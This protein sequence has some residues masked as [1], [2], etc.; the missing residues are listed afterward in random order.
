MG[1]NKIGIVPCINLF[2]LLNQIKLMDFI[3][4]TMEKI[5]VHDTTLLDSTSLVPVSLAQLIWT[6]HKIRK[7]R[8]SN[9][10]HHQKR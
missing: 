8:G 2:L 3:D 9:L 1:T 5:C 6:M 4:L 10:D 7:V